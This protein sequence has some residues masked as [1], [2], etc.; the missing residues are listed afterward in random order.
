MLEPD[1]LSSA[2]MSVICS[3]CGSIVEQD[4]LLVVRCDSTGAWVLQY[5]TDIICVVK[6]ERDA[7]NGGEAGSDGHSGQDEMSR[8][9]E[10]AESGSAAAMP[11]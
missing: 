9:N 1:S 7:A 2:R 5:S 8:R 11:T 10:S 4:A 3:A 6:E